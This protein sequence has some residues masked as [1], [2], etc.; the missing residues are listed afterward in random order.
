M[1]GRLQVARANACGL[2]LPSD[3]EDHRVSWVRTGVQKEAGATAVEFALVLPLLLLLILGI[4]EFGLLFYQ[5]AIVVTASREGARAGII[6][7]TPKPTA[8]QVEAVVSA[9]LANAGFK[10][11]NVSIAVTGAGGSFGSDLTV[12]VES[13]YQFLF[14]P[15]LVPGMKKTATLT[16]QTVMKNE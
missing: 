4:I 5:Q 15:N 1:M 13:P 6:R 2:Q 7:T 14:L 12:R 10:G 8:G 3:R 16:G 11:T 9:F